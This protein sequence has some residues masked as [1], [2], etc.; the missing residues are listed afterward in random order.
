[1]LEKAVHLSRPRLDHE[2][3]FRNQFGNEYADHLLSATVGYPK[4]L[5][6]AGS[7]LVVA[8]GIA[9]RRAAGG[10]PIGSLS[11]LIAKG[12][13]DGGKQA[14]PFMQNGTTNVIGRG[15]TLWPVGPSPPVGSTPAAPPGGSTCDRTTTGALA[16]VDASGGS[17]TRTRHYLTTQMA[18]GSAA[19]HTLV[20]SDRLW[21]V[22]P[23]LT[24]G[25]QTITG[26]PTRGVSTVAESVGNIIQIEVVATLGATAHTWSITY[27]DESGNA[28]NVTSV[29]GVSG[30]VL[31]TLDMASGWWVPLLAGDTGVRAIT[32]VNCGTTVTGTVNIKIGSPLVYIPIYA[33]NQPSIY[34]GVNSNF[35]MA[36]VKNG[37]CLNHFVIPGIATATS[38]SGQHEMVAS[39]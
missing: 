32:S 3:E 10:S 38:F 31:N 37:A 23:S 15:S 36:E 26:V 1:M 9:L 28:G 33:S 5:P 34:D 11:D 20:L 27:T 35:N 21:H 4:F 24:A 16:Q 19:P 7:N 14:I 39:D 25:A 13:A 6:V 2:R 17:P 30:A 18:N 8:D 29:V 22:R 12:T